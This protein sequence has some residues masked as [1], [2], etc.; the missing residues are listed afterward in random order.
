MS[1]SSDVD[2]VQSKPETA[3]Y[4]LPTVAWM[5][6]AGDA[7]HNFVDGL[8]IGAA[9]AANLETGIALSIAVMCHELPHELG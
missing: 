4:I 9:F 5:I 1:S 2:S 6:I 8:A 7:M 3:W